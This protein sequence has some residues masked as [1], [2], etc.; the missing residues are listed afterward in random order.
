MSLLPKKKLKNSESKSTA[1]EF[2]LSEDMMNNKDKIEAFGKVMGWKNDT[3]L[4]AYARLLENKKGFFTHDLADQLQEPLANVRRALNAL[5]QLELINKEKKKRKKALADFWT[6]KKRILYFGRSLPSSYFTK[7]IPVDFQSKVASENEISRYSDLFEFFT[8]HTQ[9]HW[10]LTK[11]ITWKIRR[12]GLMDYFERRKYLKLSNRAPFITYVTLFSS[13]DPYEVEITNEFDE[14]LPYEPN[15]FTHK[16]KDLTI[17]NATVSPEIIKSYYN[18]LRLGE[19]YTINIQ[20]KKRMYVCKLNKNKF[21]ACFHYW[22]KLRRLDALK[23]SYEFSKF[24]GAVSCEI[25]MD[26][27]RKIGEINLTKSYSEIA[28]P[29]EWTVDVKKN[30]VVVKIEGN[31]LLS[32]GQELVLIFKLKPRYAS[33]TKKWIEL[34]DTKQCPCGNIPHLMSDSLAI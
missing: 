4:K 17:A 5:E 1:S 31:Q 13:N 3:A 27:K 32:T 2:I 24:N 19:S 28:E 11:D 34:K 33:D 20:D 18:N 16:L 6:I 14:S 15:V 10:L 22:L 12:D 7:D 30:K 8:N 25:L 29:F 9:I 21:S 23:L 26:H